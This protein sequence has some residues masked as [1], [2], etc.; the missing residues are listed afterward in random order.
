MNQT[1]KQ[2]LFVDM[3]GT[4]AVFTPCDTMETLLEK[5]YFEN[6]APMQSVVD[7]V[8][9]LHQHPDIEVY[10]LSAYLSDSQYAVDEKM[11]WLDKHLP[12]VPNERRIFLPCGVDKT[13]AVPGGIRPDDFLMDDYTKN[14]NEWE[15]PARGIKL[16]N[17]INHTNGTWEHDRI[18]FD[19]PADEIA[20]N[21]YDVMK[22]NVRM[23]DEKPTIEQATNRQPDP[24]TDVSVNTDPFTEDYNYYESGDADRDREAWE[25]EMESEVRYSQWLEES[26]PFHGKIFISQDGEDDLLLFDDK[27]KYDAMV[28]WCSQQQEPEKKFTYRAEKLSAEDYA[29]ELDMQGESPRINIESTLSKDPLTPAQEFAAQLSDQPKSPDMSPAAKVYQ[30][31]RL[32]ERS[33]IMVMESEKVSYYNSENNVINITS[34]A[35]NTEKLEALC[36]TYAQGLVETTSPHPSDMRVFEARALQRSLRAYLDLPPETPENTAKY[37]D[38]SELFMRAHCI[39]NPD[40]LKDTLESTRHMMKFVAAEYERGLNQS[41]QEQSAAPAWNPEQSRTAAQAVSE[42]LMAGLERGD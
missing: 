24:Y 37:V 8:K 19:K 13:T 39:A 38:S 40:L 28:E 10:T 41:P 35:E 5:G 29:L 21:V 1:E 9:I 25:A 34:T 31:I 30:M 42:N 7:A 16:L 11:A 22:G 12:Q 15:P 3:D 17:G 18:S 2:R 4:L 6:L 36:R 26:E 14:L 27:A 32:A 20:Q 23:L 33:K